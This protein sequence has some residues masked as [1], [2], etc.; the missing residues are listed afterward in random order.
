MNSPLVYCVI[1]TV[2]G[3]DV[4]TDTLDSLREMSYPNYKILVVDNGSTDGSQQVM[5]ETYP[6]VEL[7]ENGKN[8]GVAKGRN[9]GMKYALEHGAEWIHHI[10]NDV[11]VDKD[12]LSELISVASTDERIGLLGAKIYFHA[13]P[14]TLWYAGGKVNYFTGIVSHRG[15]REEDTGQYD[16]V[17]DTD[18]IVGCS[19][20]IRRKVIEDIG[21]FD[22]IFT[23]IYS[24][25]SDYSIHAKRAGWRLVYVPQA[26]LWHRVSTSSGGKVT[27][28]RMMLKVEYNF[29]LF[30]RYAQWYHW[31]TI[32]WCIGG[33]AILYVIKE[34]FKGNFGVVISLVRGFG[35]ALGRILS[36]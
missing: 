20:L 18:Y 34:I 13:K 33:M 27:P 19:F 7:I 14:N 15:I 29:I 31:L 28:Q 21:M 17:G 1:L 30:K 32:P 8:L 9:V 10:D 16:K 6:W 11:N 24:E 5:R 4:L 22:P 36:T 3:K 23:P 2:N 26:K 35:K 25:D 12:F